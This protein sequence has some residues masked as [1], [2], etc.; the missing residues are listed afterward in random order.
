MPMSIEKM[1]HVMEGLI[2]LHRELLVLAREKTPVIVNNQVE[3]LNLIVH[4]E[5]KLLREMNELNQ[6]RIQATGEYLLARGYRP[7]PKV[8]IRD[9]S[10]LIFKAEEKKEL[11][12]L[13]EELMGLIEELRPIN[14]L[15]Q[16]LIE[17]SL[18]FINYSL[19]LFIQTPEVEAV[20]RNPQ[21]A[22]TSGVT[23]LG[24]FDSKA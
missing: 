5:N 20:Y 10:R 18:A 24:R 7:D 21:E 17:Q 9:L 2:R 3:K 11:M 8:T 23:C 16:K 19:D 4:K 22:S 6:E 14:E 15:N 12:E 1:V 13:Q